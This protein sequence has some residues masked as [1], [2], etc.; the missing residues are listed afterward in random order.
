MVTAPVRGVYVVQL[1]SAAGL[2]SGTGLA[3]GVPGGAASGVP[4]GLAWGVP[5]GAASAGLVLIG[6]SAGPPVPGVVDSSLQAAAVNAIAARH[7]A[8][9]NS[10]IGVI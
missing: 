4:G 1:C 6:P 2:A 10:F 7:N 9:R 5:G 8:R 3:S